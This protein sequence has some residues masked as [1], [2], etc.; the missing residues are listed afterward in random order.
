MTGDVEITEIGGLKM[1]NNNGASVRKLSDRSLKNNSMRNFFAVLAIILTGILF[2]AVFSLTSGAMQMAQEETMREV[3]GKFHAG[4]KAATT[5]QYESVIA[6]PMVKRSS[7]TILIGIMDNIIKHQAE[8]RYMS[9]DSQPEDMFINLEEGHI[10][11]QENEIIVDTFTLDEF[12]LPYAPGEKIPLRFSFMGEAIED[13]FVVSGW[14][15]GDNIAHASELLISESYWMKLKGSYTDED[16]INWKEEHPEDNGI[17]LKAVNLFFDNERN[18]EKKVQ[19][20]IRNAGYEPETELNYGV[21][22][23]YMSSRMESVDPFTFS[24][25]LTAVVVILITGYLI[26]YNIFQISVISDIRFY[27]LLKTIGTTKK[28]IRRLV[29]RQA[30]MLSLIGIPIGLIIGY[31]VAKI[32][33]PFALSVNEYHGMEVSLK[34]DP[35][36]LVFGAGFSALT[37]FLSSR[38]PGKIAGSVSPIEAVKYTEEGRTGKAVLQRKKKRRGRNKAGNG[39]SAVSMALSNLLR[40]K[41]S[42]FVVI[43]AISLSIVLLA[44]IMTAVGSFQ[45]D[46]YME[47]RIAGDYMLGNINVVY[48]NPRG[49]GVDIEPEFLALADRQEGVEKRQEMWVQFGAYL[50]VDDTAR[51]RFAKLAADD[52]L[53]SDTHNSDKLERILRGEKKSL[54]GNFYGYSEGLLSNL[55]VL[56]GTL[57]VSEFL[58]GKYV[59]LSRFRGNDH[60]LPEDHVYY[61]GDI[62][63]VGKATENSEMRAITNAAGEMVDTEYVNPEEKEYEVMAIVEI[64]DSMGMNLRASNACDVVLPL[65]EFGA[66]R[67]ENDESVGYAHCFKVSYEVADEDQAA[68]EAEVKDYTDHNTEMG[69]VSK[70]SL[71]GEFVNMITVIAAIGIAL[72]VVIALIGILNFIN[73]II[74]EII[75]RKREFAM[76]QSIGMTNAQLQ[77]TLICEGISYI[78]IS[79]VISFVLGSLLS[80]AILNALNNVIL[81]FEYHFQIL[82]FVIMIPLLVLVAVIAPTAAYRNLRKKSIV[83]RLRESE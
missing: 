23:A 41:R 79:G 39:F 17:G 46:S 21:N 71:R 75:S 83:E 60:L 25:L 28:Q 49:A 34:F 10:P 55:K 78:V 51:K 58:T 50:Q 40:N 31:G 30:V 36:I 13:E 67:D 35:M 16:F 74:T 48:A 73:A 11:V 72:A 65:S 69:Y 68:F 77:K 20:V 38:K 57:D 9:K 7:Y 76:L 64:P 42:A 26:I 3:G 29:R 59:L 33:L 4:L 1:K 44:I 5:Q 66:D 80:W 54:D 15:Q 37:V 24:I 22:W 63:T 53:R 81:F 61:P 70:D 8:L 45:I 82:P 52:K 27:G 14:Y 6:D 18:L 43:M 12:N 62:V 19:T 32:A 47:Q 2:T 56:D